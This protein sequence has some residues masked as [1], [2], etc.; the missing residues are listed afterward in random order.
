MTSYVIE[1]IGP[2]GI[3][4]TTLV[5]SLVR[6]SPSTT[7]KKL[8]SASQA[9]CVPRLSRPILVK[10]FLQHY[11]LSSNGCQPSRLLFRRRSL[12]TVLRDSISEEWRRFIGV[13]L[14]IASEDSR[15]SE[16]RLLGVNFVYTSI[17]SRLFFDTWPD[18]QHLILMDE[19]LGYRP[20]MFDTGEAVPSSSVKKYYESLPL[21][22][23]IIHLSA[24]NET[25]VE[26]IC[27]RRACGQT[28]HRHNNLSLSEIIDDTKWATDLAE[29]AVQFME[30]RGVPVLCINAK[31]ALLDN[32]KKSLDFLNGL[33]LT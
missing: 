7:Q 16:D 33:N 29:Y 20:S 10:K 22:A 26:R 24:P 21:P 19:P 14:E 30:Q 15:Y 27:Q 5:R 2:A 1:I 31:G 17:A 18:N 6:Q 8:L 11:L 25:I 23:A 9:L 3:G 13:C 28:A 12:N 4:K 32:V